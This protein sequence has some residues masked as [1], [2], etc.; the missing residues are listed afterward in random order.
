[1]DTARLNLFARPRRT[2][3]VLV[4]YD[5]HLVVGELAG[6]KLGS[7]QWLRDEAVYQ[8]HSDDEDMAQWVDGHVRGRSRRFTREEA[9]ALVRAGLEGYYADLR[10]EH[11]AELA[12]ENAYVRAQEDRWDPEAQADLELHNFLHPD[13]Y[14]R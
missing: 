3:G 9:F 14:G 1:M 8:F 5:I 4:G 2:D 11:Q 13:G 7:L 10:A 12:G 6:P